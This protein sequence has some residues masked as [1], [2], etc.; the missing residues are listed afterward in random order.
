MYFLF[1]YLNIF[2]YICT[3]KQ[4]VYQLLKAKIQQK[5]LSYASKKDKNYQSSA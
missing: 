5:K 4:R 1:G 3:H 2:A